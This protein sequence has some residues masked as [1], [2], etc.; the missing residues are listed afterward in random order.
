MRN[1]DIRSKQILK[2]VAAL[3][4]FGADN[5]APIGG[6]RAY[7]NIILSRHVNR[8]MMVHLRKNLYVTKDYLDNAERKGTF[9]DSGEFTANKLYPPS[10]LSLDYVLHEHNM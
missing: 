4:F 3:P 8:G 6:K 9:S 1:D 10:Y 5:L 7:L 2:L